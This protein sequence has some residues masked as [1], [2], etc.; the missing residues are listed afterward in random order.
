MA[1]GLGQMAIV[2]LTTRPLLPFLPEYRSDKD[3][4]R[5]KHPF[6]FK[7]EGKGT[8]NSRDMGQKIFK[9]RINAKNSLENHS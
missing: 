3:F 5:K 6:I 4:H 9:N 8:Q 1:F 7:K 2:V